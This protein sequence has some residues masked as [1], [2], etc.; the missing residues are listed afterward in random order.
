MSTDPFTHTR[1]HTRVHA[2]THTHTHTHAR[3]HAHARARAHTHT[4]THTL[5]QT[6]THTHTCSHTLSLILCKHN[7]HIYAERT[8]QLPVVVHIVLPLNSQN[9]VKVQIAVQVHITLDPPKCTQNLLLSCMTTR[10]TF[11]F[12]SACRVILRSSASPSP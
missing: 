1:T 11:D 6:H 4:H 5:I 8:V 10:A 12:F 2:H 7:P 3:T 9:Q